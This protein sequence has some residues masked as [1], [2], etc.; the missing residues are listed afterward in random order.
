MPRYL[1]PP[2]AEYSQ[3]LG[4]HTVANKHSL[5]LGCLFAA[6]NRAYLLSREARPLLPFQS[7]FRMKCPAAFRLLGHLA[8][9]EQL[10]G[11]FLLP[12]TPPLC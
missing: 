8:A 3:E 9:D 2:G 10:N 7:V 6:T 11:H 5:L 12:K 4:K 1:S